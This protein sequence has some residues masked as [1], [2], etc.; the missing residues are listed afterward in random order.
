MN[1]QELQPNQLA[2][3]LDRYRMAFD[4]DLKPLVKRLPFCKSINEKD[5]DCDH[6]Q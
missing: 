5:E 6:E 4:E 1:T 2:W 3:V